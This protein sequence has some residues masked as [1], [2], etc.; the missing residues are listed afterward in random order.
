MMLKEE[1]LATDCQAI[2]ETL[3]EYRGEIDRLDEVSRQHLEICPGC[4]E[5]AAAE[6]ALGLIFEQAVPPADARIEGAVLAALKPVRIRRRFVAFVPV[7]VSLLVALVGAV[8]VGGI[9]GI[10]VVTLLPRWSADGWMAF[11]TSASDWA[12]AVAA[13]ARASAAVLDPAILA[14]V[15]MVSF[16][17]LVGVAVT[18]L[19]WRKISPWRNDS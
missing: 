15:G 9:P 1:N 14:G 2:Q 10:G 17:G 8:L 19:R 7:A 16:L 3:T 6:R 13:G 11:V 18:A 12:T 4:R 5:V